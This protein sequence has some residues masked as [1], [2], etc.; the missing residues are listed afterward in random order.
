M[1]TQSKKSVQGVCIFKK[2]NAKNGLFECGD[3][4]S[5]SR[6]KQTKG[7]RDLK[8]GLKWLLDSLLSDLVG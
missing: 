8:Y 4:Y 7:D 3:V 6:K 5:K 2:K 1:Q